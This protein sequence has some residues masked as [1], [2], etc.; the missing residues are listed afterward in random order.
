MLGRVILL[1]AAAAA[2][3][4]LVPPDGS[5]DIGGVATAGSSS[6]TADGWDISASGSDIWVSIFISNA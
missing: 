2:S 5:V 6:Q 3:A 1:L 4:Q